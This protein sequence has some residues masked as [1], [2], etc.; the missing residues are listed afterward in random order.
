MNTSF[1]SEIE[2]LLQE[3]SLSVD[4]G[5]N[6]LQWMKS[7]ES[8]V[9]FNPLSCRLLRNVPCAF[10][11]VWD[12]PISGE[13]QATIA[14]TWT[15]VKGIEHVD[16]P[17]TREFWKDMSNQAKET[18]LH[19]YV[20]AGETFHANNAS[21]LSGQSLRVP[22]YKRIDMGKNTLSCYGAGLACIAIDA[23]SGMV[24]AEGP[25]GK[26][27]MK[28]LSIWYG[29]MSAL[30]GGTC[31]ACYTYIIE[32][33]T[34]IELGVEITYKLLG[35]TLTYEVVACVSKE[36]MSKVTFNSIGYGN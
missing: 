6:N 14:K 2:Q 22:V 1:F 32:S 34:E 17:S 5:I 27:L 9:V 25:S 10:M 21:I 28:P 20:Y 4:G 12:K 35:K 3:A 13:A 23:S 29:K 33:S 19:V 7:K 36:D 31:S 18:P 16:Q 30:V 11:V 15:L 24:V 8:A 26:G